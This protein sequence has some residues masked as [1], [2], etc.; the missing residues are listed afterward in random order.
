MQAS[1]KFNLPISQPPYLVHQVERKNIYHTILVDKDL[2]F[3]TEVVTFS[4]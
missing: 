3:T 1:D 2:A 4:V